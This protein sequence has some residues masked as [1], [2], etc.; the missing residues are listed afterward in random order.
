VIERV[1]DGLVGRD[2][3]D[4]RRGLVTEHDATLGID[5]DDAVRRRVQNP[6]EPVQGARVARQVGQCT[7]DPCA[8]SG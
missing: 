5:D 4:A 6:C 3:E 1:P 2:G 8:G 7:V